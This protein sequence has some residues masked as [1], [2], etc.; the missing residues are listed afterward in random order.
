MPH[1]AGQAPRPACRATSAFRLLLRDPSAMVPAMAAALPTT[2][3]SFPLHAVLRSPPAVTVIGIG[4]LALAL[5]LCLIADLTSIPE[6]D[7]I[8]YMAE[9]FLLI[10][11]LTPGYKHV[12]S[13][14]ISW[15]VAL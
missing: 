6:S 2:P 9:G 15:L 4:L 12:P 11:G 14:A 10:E 7:E 1:P 13:A 5:R 8:G 3:T